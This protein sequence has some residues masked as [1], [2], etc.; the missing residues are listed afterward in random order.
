MDT[1]PRHSI[2]T[3]L[4]MKCNAKHITGMCNS[5]SHSAPY[6]LL[7]SFSHETED[8]ITRKFQGL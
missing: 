7:S 1:L 2:E 8:Y 4:Y 3:Q 5:H 6:I